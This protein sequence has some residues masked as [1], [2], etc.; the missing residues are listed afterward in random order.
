M[1][2]VRERERERDVQIVVLIPKIG[3]GSTVGRGGIAQQT[4]YQK[5]KQQWTKRLYAGTEKMK[6]LVIIVSLR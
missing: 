1:S 4:D 2:D 5:T 6:L 3:G